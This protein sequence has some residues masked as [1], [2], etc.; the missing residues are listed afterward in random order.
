M[1]YASLLGLDQALHD[2]VNSEQLEDR[3]IP[4]LPLGSTSNLSK[5][6]NAQGGYCGNALQA[7][8]DRGHDQVVQ[9]LL[10]KGADVNAQCGIYGNA[11][12]AASEGGYEQVVQMLLDNGVDVNAQGGSYGNALQ[13]DPTLVTFV[14]VPNAPRWGRHVVIS[15][16][17]WSAAGRKDSISYAWGSFTSA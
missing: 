1:Y 9:M 17:P 10:D 13:A 4:A 16:E 14:A 11:L 2:L 5:K 12:Q 8:S 15:M 6:I 7:A 3:T